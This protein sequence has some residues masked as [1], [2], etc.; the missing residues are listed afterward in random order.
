MREQGEGQSEREKQ[1]PHGAGEPDDTGLDPR[2]LGSQPEPK[3]DIQPL[4]H[5]DKWHC[6]TILQISSESGRKEDGFP[7][8]ICFAFNLLQ[9]VAVLEVYTELWP[10]K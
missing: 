7:S 3:A 10:H 8:H 6:H 2:T 1:A 9:Y 5:P 4:S